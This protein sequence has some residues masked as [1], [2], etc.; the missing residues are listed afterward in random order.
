[1]APLRKLRR[2]TEMS[3]LRFTDFKKIEEQLQLMQFSIDHTFDAVFGIDASARFIYVNESAC[4]QLGYSRDELLNMTIHDVNPDFPLEEWSLSWQKIKKAVSFAQESRHRNKNGTIISIEFKANYFCLNDKEFIFAFAK[5]ITEQKRLEELNRLQI[6]L[7]VTLSTEIKPDEALPICLDYAIQVSGMDCGGIYLISEKTGDIESPYHKGLSDEFIRVMSNYKA[8]DQM[9]LIRAGNSIYMD[10]QELCI[11]E[12]SL[13]IQDGLKSVAAIPILYDGKINACLNVGSHTLE[14]ITVFARNA[15][16]AIATQI[17]SAIAR[18]RA[19]DALKKSE[20]KYRAL[21]ENSWDAFEL[22][23]ANGN[24]LYTSPAAA[25][26]SGYTVQEL[27]GRNVINKMVPEYRAYAQQII[28]D[29]VPKHGHTVNIQLCAQHKDGS[30]KWLEGICTN[31]LNEPSIQAIVVNYRDVTERKEA[32]DALKESEEKY[33]RLIENAKEG[34]GVIQNRIIKFANP[35]I[36][37]ITGNSY[38][39]LVNRDFINIIYP[40]DRD[41]V[42]DN[43]FKKLKGEKIKEP[44]LYRIVSKDES[45]KWI[46]SA[47]VLINWDGNPAI[48]IFVSDVTEKRKMEETLLRIQKLESIGTLAGGIAH[49]FNNILTGILG[50]ISL[51]EMLIDQKDKALERLAEAERSASKAKDL[52]SQLLTFSKGGAPILKT[53]SITDILKESVS[54]ALSGSKSTHSFFFPNDVWSVVIDDGQMNQV[55]NNILINADQAMPQG[56]M[57]KIFAQN[58]MVEE[59]DILS[60]EAGPYVKISVEDQ[61]IGIPEEHLSRIFD[62]YFS[63]KQKGSGL[64]L[65]ITYSIIKRHN[66][67]IEVESQLGIGTKIHFYVPAAP[68]QVTKRKEE[69][70]DKSTKG[71]GKVLVMDDQEV[72]RDILSQMLTKIG[73]EIVTA[74][75][76][77]EAIE[78]FIDSKES[79]F[80]F[81]A[82]IMDLTI[83]G[84]MGGIEAIAKLRDIDP[85]IRAIVSSG[86]SNDPVMS[87]FEKYG[88]KGVIAKP[89]R[90]QE[91]RDIL[92]EVLEG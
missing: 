75:D 26:F 73:Y 2:S 46:E 3:H 32:I 50:N 18:L 83:P 82:V 33:R 20:E 58:V 64:G 40:D 78:L 36:I 35:K 51:A 8:G 37:E 59:N 39:E 9:T 69:T 68:D 5:D 89:Y 49:D 62:P 52:T 19:E 48:L 85:Q 1:M 87:N 4:L 63:T 44:I 56:G 55:I 25:K 28:N 16:E 7:G 76:G 15:L 60:L 70:S 24:T 31:L 61:G 34:I 29:L 66:G 74:I 91:L 10:Y 54:F 22:I 88:F 23:D 13:F 17:G 12:K 14:N 41:K 11:K 71:R 79:G 72:I 47:G 53:T 77:T 45:I 43:Y 65:A 42:M 38:K 80:P 84:G 90:P 67:H 6:E 81:D 27:I 86:Y 30:L 92:Q 21:I 57:I